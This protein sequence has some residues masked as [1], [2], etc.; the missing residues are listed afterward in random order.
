VFV[1]ELDVVAAE[2]TVGGS[3][4]VDGPRSF[5]SRMIAPDGKTKEILADAKLFGSYGLERP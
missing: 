5:K 4:A 3:L 2:M 1:G